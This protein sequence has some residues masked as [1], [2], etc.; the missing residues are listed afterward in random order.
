LSSELP[1][2]EFYAEGWLPSTTI[3]HRST[4]P[5]RLAG[6]A[7]AMSGHLSNREAV[8]ELLVAVTGRAKFVRL[9]ETAQQANEAVGTKRDAL[10]VFR[11]LAEITH[12]LGR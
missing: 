2:V 11:H 1:W 7:A 8:H 4:F 6:R 10:K 9:D 3:C 5:G 12:F